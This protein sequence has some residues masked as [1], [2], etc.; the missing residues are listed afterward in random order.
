MSGHCPKCGD[1]CEEDDSRRCAKCATTP[2]DPKAAEEWAYKM[3]DKLRDLEISSAPASIVEH[4]SL[5][6]SLTSTKLAAMRWERAEP[7]VKMTLAQLA[8]LETL[9]IE[10]GLPETGQSLTLLRSIGEALKG[11]HQ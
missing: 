1:Y 9:L 2:D 11:L 5:L 3:S 4:E 6:Y 7:V 8:A 10:R